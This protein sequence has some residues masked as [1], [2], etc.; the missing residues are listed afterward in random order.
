MEQVAFLAQEWCV[1][2][3]NCEAHEKNALSIKLAGLVFGLGGFATGAPVYLILIAVLLC[4]GQE[5]IVR[6]WQGRL[7]DR[8]LIV[9]A[10]LARADETGNFAMQLHTNWR[11]QRSSGTHLVLGYMRHA[12][13]PTVAFPYLPLLLLGAM[14]VVLQWM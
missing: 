7:E 13:R 12:V 3:N 1:L 4:W 14:G 2:Q 5:A 6:T 8:L 11:S 10:C 9:E